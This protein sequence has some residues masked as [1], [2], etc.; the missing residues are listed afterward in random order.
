MNNPAY[1]RN[2]LENVMHRPTHVSSLD[3]GPGS[4]P[5]AKQHVEATVLT[6]EGH[7]YVGTNACMRPQRECP[8][9]AAGFET[10]Q[11]YHLCQEVCQQTAHAEVNALLAAGG[12][13]RGATLIVKGHSYACRNCLDAAKRAG[14]L[15]VV[16]GGGFI[17][18]NV[19][20]PDRGV[21]PIVETA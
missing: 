16:V 20:D 7:R 8:R 1:D 17:R 4:G 21:V 11:G 12:H 6:P 15:D 9:D 18:L 5:C 3:H 2:W 10:G 14:I 19:L 13:A